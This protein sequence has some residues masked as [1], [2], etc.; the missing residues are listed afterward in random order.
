M[1]YLFTSSTTNANNSHYYLI[2]LVLLTIKIK[3]LVVLF[4]EKAHERKKTHFQNKYYLLPKR[5]IKKQLFAVKSGQPPGKK[6]NFRN[7]PFN[8]SQL[9]KILEL[10]VITRILFHS[11]FSVLERLSKGRVKVEKY[12]TN[13]SSGNTNNSKSPYATQ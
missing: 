1:T 6:K 13:A 8:L 4:L 10:H 2:F 3:Q 7:T 12:L 5:S 9:G 11:I